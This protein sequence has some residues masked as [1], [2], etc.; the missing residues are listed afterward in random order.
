MGGAENFLEIT[1]LEVGNM[2]AE[3]TDK[4]EAG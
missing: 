4:R 2:E 1:A 3:R